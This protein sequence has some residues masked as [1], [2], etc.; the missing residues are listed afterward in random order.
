MKEN[1]RDEK[2]P[3]ESLATA[4]QSQARAIWGLIETLSHQQHIHSLLHRLENKIDNIMATQA[5]LSADLRA[6]NAQQIKTATE[7][8]ALQAGQDALTAKIVELQAIVDAGGAIGQELIDAVA[9]VK[10]Q[11][12]TN[13][14][15]IP[16]VPAPPV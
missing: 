13:D 16:D 11:S 5:E 9:A 3:D 12:Q 7:I 4:I 14:E 2:R 6:V 1:N 10:A 15:L 8:V